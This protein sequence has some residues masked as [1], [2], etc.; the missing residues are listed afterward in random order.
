ML[1]IELFGGLAGLFL[2]AWLLSK[3]ETS[4]TRLRN[5]ETYIRNQTALYRHYSIKAT[6]DILRGKI[7][8]QG[9]IATIS[10]DQVIEI[11]SRVRH[12]RGMGPIAYHH[13]P[14]YVDK[15]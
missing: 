15:E 10:D 11:V 13:L 5:A 7:G 1:I 9:H 4:D 6:Q 3:K 14:D 8:S 2:G 12:E